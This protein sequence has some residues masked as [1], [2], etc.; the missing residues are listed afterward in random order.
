MGTCGHDE[1]FARSAI[2]FSFVESASRQDWNLGRDLARVRASEEM[3]QL[4]DAPAVL[5]HSNPRVGNFTL[6]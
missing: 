4:D 3:L 6:P 1:S 5:N 2:R